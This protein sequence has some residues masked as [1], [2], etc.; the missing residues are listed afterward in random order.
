MSLHKK[1]SKYV[2]LPDLDA[3]KAKLLSD[4]DAAISFFKSG[5]SSFGLGLNIAN[6][7][8]HELVINHYCL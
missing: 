4:K 3:I 7:M 1:V 8:I 5:P 2:N 6:E